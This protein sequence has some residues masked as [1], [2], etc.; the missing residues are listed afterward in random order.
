MDLVN[1]YLNLSEAMFPGSPE[2]KKKF[3]SSFNPYDPEGK[4][5]KALKLQPYGYRDKADSDE[6]P[7]QQPASKTRGR[8][9]K[10]SEAMSAVG[11]IDARF[12]KL[13]GR[14]MGD[15]AKEHG[16]E[17][18]RLQKE[19][20][21]QAAENE[22]RKAAMK[23]EE[24][25]LDEAT[26]ARSATKSEYQKSLKTLEKM[27]EFGAMSKSLKR[28]DQDAEYEKRK[29]DEFIKSLKKE[30]AKLDEATPSRQQVKQAIGIT[31]DKRYA[32]GNVSGAVRAM[33]KLNPG[34]AQ[35]PVVKREL[36]KQN[37][38]IESIEEL[39][40]TTLASYAKKGVSDARFKQGIGKDFEAVGKRKRDPNTKALYARMGQKLRMKAK[41][42]EA[43]VV[44]AI[45][46]LAKEEVE[47]DERCWDGYT[48]RGMK[49]KDGRMVP[50][51]V[52]TTE[53]NDLV[54]RYLSR[55]SVH[56][57]AVTY[58][59]GFRKMSP[60]KDRFGNK[61]KNVAQHL[62]RQGMQAA[63]KDLKKGPE[64]GKKQVS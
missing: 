3:D 55:A 32:K 43:G 19:I 26:N 7:T 31:R 36:Q 46:R 41:G 63:I 12:K 14:S 50:N 22:R 34:L 61:V 57:E 40:K 45:D 30:G 35:H 38:E 13:S 20:D 53:Q 9:K 51:C 11:R 29:N 10:M 1:K 16:A 2:Y 56:Q 60:V 39:S 62:A 47:I 25:D 23:K 44:K 4:V 49:K 59:S 52:P 27:P 6:K 5:K 37:E 42:R 28:R 8:P 18:K 54:S 17:V 33:D 24:A 48:A 64:A 15:A 58:D 21:A